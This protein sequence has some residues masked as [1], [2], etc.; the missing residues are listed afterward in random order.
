MKLFLRN[1]MIFMLFI[2]EAALANDANAP[3]LPWAQW[4]QQLRQDALA[5]GVSPA[6]FDQVFAGLKPNESILHF[7]RHQPEK[8][9]TFLE[10]RQSRADAYRIRLGQREYQRNRSLLTQAGQQFGVDPC[11]I[12]AIWGLETSY[13]RYLGKYPVIQALA[14]LAYDTRRGDQFRP[15]LL[16]ALLILQGG[17]VR[18]QDFKGEWAGASGQPQFMPSSWM[19]YAVDFDGDGH[20]NIWTDYGDAFASIA[21]YLALNGWHNGEPWAVEVTLPIGFDTNL[22]KT[23]EQRPVNEWQGLGL[24][25]SHGSLPE[26]TLPATLLYPDGGPALLVF[27]NFD[28]IKRYNN[29][30]FYAGTIGYLA[31]SICH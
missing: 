4:V 20:K 3:R 8:R 2:G 21:N 19:K 13:G 15:E 1:L 16:T 11:I 26:S 30:T 22:L 17:H 7:D 5:E 12:T 24:R 10:Y 18:S 27:H 25:A 28:V 31:D 29:S 14:T 6:L 9:I 23:S